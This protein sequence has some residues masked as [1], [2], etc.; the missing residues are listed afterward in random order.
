MSYARDIGARE[1]LYGA[2]HHIPD[3]LVHLL[4]QP[5]GPTTEGSGMLSRYRLTRSATMVRLA[6]L[7]ALAIV[8]SILAS[9]GPAGAQEGR[10]AEVLPRTSACVGAALDPFGFEDVAD[11]SD[12]R[13][14]AINCIAY[15]GVT[16][17]RTATTFDPDSNVTRSQMALFLYRAAGAGG[18][19]FTLTADDPVAMFSDIGDLGAEWQEA[20]QALY[21]K[22]IMS[23]RDGSDRAAV[24]SASSET[25]VPDDP[26]NRAEMAV[27]L[28]NLVRVASPDLFDADGELLG[29][30]SLDQFTDAHTTTPAAISDA[31][32]TVFELG[33]TVGQSATT[34]DPPGFVRRSNMALFLTRT[35]AHTTA[36]PAGLSVQ[37]DGTV[38]V[39]TLRDRRFQPVDTSR[40]EFVDVFVADVDDADDAFD[41]DGSCDTDV[42]R[43]VPRWHHD[44][45]VIDVGD[46]LFED[47]DAEIDLGE[48]LTSEGFM[49]WVWIGSLGDEADEEDT[50]SVE[51]DPGDLPPPAPSQLT[52]T[53]TGLRS[54]PDGSTVMT[55][56]KG[57]T[58]RVNLQL[59]GAYADETD[60]VPAVTPDGGAM[61]E[62]VLVTTVPDGSDQDAERDVYER[63]RVQDIALAADGSASF[64]LPTHR[65]DDYAVEYSV[66]A[67]GDAPF[68]DPAS[69][70]VHFT[71]SDP[72]VASVAVDPLRDWLPAGTGRDDEARNSV[73][74]TV[75][76]QYGR[77]MSGQTVLLTSDS[78]GFSVVARGRGYITSRS[79]VVVGYDRSGVSGVETLTAGIDRDA[80][81]ESGHGELPTDC[82]NLPN[83]GANSN[84]VCGHAEV[85]WTEQADLSSGNDTY[86]VVQADVRDQKIIVQEQGATTLVVVDY[87]DTAS[88]DVF[89]VNSQ[90]GGRTYAEDLGAFEAAL[91]DVNDSDDEYQL[92][93]DQTVSR[94]WTFDLITP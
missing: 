42:V 13:L 10:S 34:Y 2:R 28:R 76:D 83:S 66:T 63:S 73:R 24:G 47:G 65:L 57:T 88:G 23:G 45:C 55:A 31:I 26:I 5:L 44:A 93:W 89:D 72:V 84:D 22:G 68:A 46:A 81:D 43:E 39:V 49:T 37:Q 16:M 50:L 9:A 11:L 36:R 94:R 58:V 82:A 15:Y 69:G 51:F 80:D 32:A 90:P 61:Y 25:F 48:D 38:L 79:G 8:G 14:D 7:A 1:R 29:V 21:G 12:E 74:V 70:V 67:V 75:F 92:V 17:G 91:A 52:V 41:S 78:S 33:I 27:Y 87:A 53:F 56:R 85:Y 35:L 20:I 59:E 4:A 30:A 18:V 6:M 62:L 86:I 54:Q 3:R 77:P 19:D 40:N 60:L 64:T 71:N